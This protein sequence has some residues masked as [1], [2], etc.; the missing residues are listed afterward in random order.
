MADKKSDARTTSSVE[1]E[2][3]VVPTLAPSKAS[4]ES[5]EHGCQE[6]GLDPQAILKSIAILRDLTSTPLTIDAFDYYKDWTV[7]AQ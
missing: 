2:K 4:P 3:E 6:E 5:K 7:D 1:P